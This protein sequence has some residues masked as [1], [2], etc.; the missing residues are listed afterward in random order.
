MEKYRFILVP[1]VAL[2]ICQI[3]KFIIESIISKRLRFD[4][5]FNG[6]GGM[7]SS[8]TTFSVALTTLVWLE[9]GLMSPLFAICLIFSMV[10]SYDAIGVRYES[11]K[12]AEAINDLVEDLITNK[13][14][15]INYKVLKEQLGHKPLEVLGGLILGFVV[16]FIFYY[17]I[18]GNL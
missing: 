1:F 6:A 14:Q 9:E 2:I 16:S 11:G 8:H 12:Q 4:R 7:P 10:V 5:L 18:F 3:I 17:L 15:K 13:K